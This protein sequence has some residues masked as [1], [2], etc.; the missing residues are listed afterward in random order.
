MAVA[1]T[2]DEI[3]STDRRAAVRPI[4]TPGFGRRTIS[5][6]AIAPLSAATTIQR[7][8]TLTSPYVEIARHELAAL[9][10]PDLPIDRDAAASPR[11]NIRIFMTSVDID[12]IG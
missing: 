7:D 9:I 4:E 3:I 8:A 2:M 12:P 10:D 6:N 1:A 11:R 5:P